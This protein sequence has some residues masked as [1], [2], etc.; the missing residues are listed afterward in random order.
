LVKI[1]LAPSPL[2]L[3]IFT[4]FVLALQLH[5][6]LTFSYYLSSFFFF[7][8]CITSAFLLCFH[9]PSPKDINWHTPS[10][11]IIQYGTYSGDVI[12]CKHCSNVV[13][14]FF[15]LQVGGEPSSA[16]IPPPL[17]ASIRGMV[18]WKEGRKGSTG[19]TV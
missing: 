1:L 10:P 15:I 19:S 13:S 7:L 16:F 8:L 11:H 9:I 18:P 17:P 6:L 5:W 3:F 12:P 4:H 2:L 14:T